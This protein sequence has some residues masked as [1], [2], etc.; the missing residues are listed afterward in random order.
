MIMDVEVSKIFRPTGTVGPIAA[1]AAGAK[2]LG[3]DDGADD[4]CARARREHGGRLQRVGRHG[5][6]RDVLPQRLRRAQ[7]RD[8]R[9]ARRRRRVR[10][11]HRARR[12]RR[13]AR[14][15]PPAATA[16]SAGAVRGPP[17][18]PGRVLQAR[19]GVQL[20]ANAG[21]GGA[22]A[23]AAA[24]PPRRRHRQGHACASRK[25]RRSTPAA[26]R[27]GRSST[28]CKRR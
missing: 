11:A 17:R 27:A 25:P 15:V 12:R 24:P 1:A 28:S 6:Q 20:R 3:L 10:V 8:G 26:T 7:R 22:R 21:A 18:D 14:G 19:A 2:L 16:A 23:R 4:D 13:H 5:R 9:A